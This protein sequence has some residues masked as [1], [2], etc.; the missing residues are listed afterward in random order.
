M[1][2]MVTSEGNS[3]SEAYG[4]TQQ[5][6]HQ[7]KKHNMKPHN[8]FT[9]GGVLNFGW[10]LFVTLLKLICQILTC[11]IMVQQAM[12]ACVINH[13]IL[14]ISFLPQ[15]IISHFHDSCILLQWS[16]SNHF[17]PPL[18]ANYIDKNQAAPQKRAECSVLISFS[19]FPSK[20]ISPNSS[21]QQCC[22]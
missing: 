21:H 7:S 11:S 19:K 2:S 18:P 3:C 13:L 8:W 15:S 4:V 9:I 1:K 20:T 22:Q 12:L 10:V 6:V 14:I 16:M 5:Q 17:Q